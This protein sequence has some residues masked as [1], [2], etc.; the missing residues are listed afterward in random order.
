MED[1][2]FYKHV[3]NAMRDMVLVKGPKSRLIWGNQSFLDYYGMTEADLRGIV[4]GPQSDPDDTLQYVRDDKRVFDTR[5][6][7]NVPSE[8]VTDSAGNV[9]YY[10]TIKSPIVERNEVT[11]TVGVSRLI[12]DKNI[13]QHN[14]T[15]LDAKVFTAPLRSIIGSFPMATMLLDHDRRVIKCN[16]R[17]TGLFGELS[18]GANHEFDTHYPALVELVDATETCL[19]R[20]AE[21]ETVIPVTVRAS[22]KYFD[23]KTSL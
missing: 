23:F 1:P 3:L 6:D 8:P 21:I 16:E 19:Q 10:H 2:E 20:N 18:A 7:L 12:D 13:P 22:S 11:H 9:A 14:L 15:E 4:D 17:W 5:Q